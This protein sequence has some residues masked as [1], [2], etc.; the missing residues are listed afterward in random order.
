MVIPLNNN[1]QKIPLFNAENRIKK[2]R[3]KRLVIKNL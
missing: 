3:K 2:V 1:I